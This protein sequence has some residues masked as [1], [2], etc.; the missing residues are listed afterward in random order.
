[1]AHP[2]DI[3][4]AVHGNYGNAWVAAWVGAVEHAT[5]G[6]NAASSNQLLHL[7]GELRELLGFE[8]GSEV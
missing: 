8:C 3:A 4:E 6:T 7:C 5:H 2:K 1:M